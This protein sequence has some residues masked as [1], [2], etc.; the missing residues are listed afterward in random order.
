MACN[1]LISSNVVF[2][3]LCNFFLFTPSGS[4]SSGH[5]CCHPFINMNY[6]A[7]VY[8]AAAAAE[9]ATAMAFRLILIRAIHAKHTSKSNLPPSL[10]FTWR[11]LFA[12]RLSFLCCVGR[13]I[14]HSTIVCMQNMWLV[15]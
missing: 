7:Y 2:A 10:L 1:F 6:I 12:P 5:I 13:S 8:A 3:V 9:C 14:P 4:L 15:F 11:A